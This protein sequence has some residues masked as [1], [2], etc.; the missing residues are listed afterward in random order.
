MG[1]FRT[2]SISFIPSVPFA[3]LISFPGSAWERAGLEALPPLRLA[4]PAMQ[5]VPR[6]SLGTRA[7]LFRG[8][9][10]KSQNTV[11]AG[12]GVAEEH[13]GVVFVEERIVDTGI[14]GR[15]ASFE[16]NDFA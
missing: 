16:H 10:Q 9:F 15:H 12:F 5:W 1:L 11:D 7:G 6:Q 2:L 3:L 14:A 13:T 8:L 4:E